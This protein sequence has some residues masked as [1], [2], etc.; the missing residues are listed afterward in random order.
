MQPLTFFQ[1]CFYYINMSI[2]VIKYVNL[3][4]ALY[5]WYFQKSLFIWMLYAEKQYSSS[6]SVHFIVIYT[7]QNWNVTQ[8]K[9]IR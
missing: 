8:K 7:K 2:I 9:L 5:D 6:K 1:K 3:R 4:C